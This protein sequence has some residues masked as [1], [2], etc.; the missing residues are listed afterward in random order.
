M[1]LIFNCATCKLNFEIN[2]VKNIM[3]FKKR[4]MLCRNFHKSNS[5]THHLGPSLIKFD[6]YMDPKM[7][8]C[9]R[10]GAMYNMGSETKACKVCDCVEFH[11]KGVSYV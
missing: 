11:S 8:Q 2:S 7:K 9:K 4:C 10:C 5:K 1:M 6:Y 3:R